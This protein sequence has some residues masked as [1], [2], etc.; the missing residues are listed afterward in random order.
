MS[1]AVQDACDE[2]LAAPMHGGVD[3]LYV[4][5][6]AAVFFYEVWRRREAVVASCGNPSSGPPD[7]AQEQR[8]VGER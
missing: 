6:A 3:S 1:V 2:L 4:G 5:A 8:P 7:Q